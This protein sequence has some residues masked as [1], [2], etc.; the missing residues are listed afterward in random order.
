MKRTAPFFLLLLL[1]A[2]SGCTGSSTTPKAAAVQNPA[3]AFPET[4]VFSDEASAEPAAAQLQK[5][6]TRLET[7]QKWN[8]P[9]LLR[10][11]FNRLKIPLPEACARWGHVQVIVPEPQSDE[12]HEGPVTRFLFVVRE[13]APVDA[14]GDEPDRLGEE[15]AGEDDG[16][17]VDAGEPADA[18]DDVDGPRGP[19]DEPAAKK[20]AAPEDTDDDV[21][22]D[23][24]IAVHTCAVTLAPGAT[25]GRLRIG[26]V[27]LLATRTAPQV[28]R[29]TAVEDF[30][31]FHLSLPHEQRAKDLHPLADAVWSPGQVLLLFGRGTVNAVGDWPEGAR[32]WPEA[33][34]EFTARLRL[35]PAVRRLVLVLQATPSDTSDTSDTSDGANTFC[36]WIDGT[37]RLAAIS[38]ADARDLSR[39]AGLSG[40]GLPV[41][42]PSDDEGEREVP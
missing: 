36:A 22:D 37:G 3:A 26:V 5:L 34:L 18:K 41:E 15:P 17:E 27:P 20:G 16:G 6:V 39:E 35:A 21:P 29:I 10:T 30:S 4:M 33:G 1:V 11:V 40:C 25:A 14:S 31:L 38:A 12:A 9:L 19:E 28:A 23:A 32:K 13:L 42:P 7:A 8:R 24:P 2:L